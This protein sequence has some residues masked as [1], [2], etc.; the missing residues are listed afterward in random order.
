MI[1]LLVVVAI[2]GILATVGLVGFRAYIDTS[3]DAVTSDGFNFVKRQLNQD[4]LSLRNDLSAKSGLADNLSIR[5]QCMNVRDE[6]ISM[7]NSE[8]RSPFN[9][10]LG[11]VCDGNH[12]AT[13]VGTPAGRPTSVRLLRGQTMVYCSGT[14]LD[15]A[16][17]APV[18]G[19]IGL[20]YCTCTSSDSCETQ[21]RR[22]GQIQTG[23]IDSSRTIISIDI[24]SSVPANLRNTVPAN[25]QVEGRAYVTVSGSLVTANQWDIIISPPL[26]AGVTDNNTNITEVGQGICFTPIGAADSASYFGTYTSF[27]DRASLDAA[28]GACGAVN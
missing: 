17:F 3:K 22:T 25:I 6:Y 7:I 18:T 24:D 15:S 26:A 9:E 4:L 21:L 12:L 1:E 19:T 8:R 13:G 11:A 14:D 27:A 16:M 2:I 10:L 5:S 20:N 28:F 23:G